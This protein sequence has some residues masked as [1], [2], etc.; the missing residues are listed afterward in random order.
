MR[1]LI[2]TL[3]A[4]LA[5]VAIPAG[6]TSSKLV[7][8]HSHWDGTNNDYELKFCFKARAAAPGAGPMF[9]YLP[10]RAQDSQNYLQLD[11]T[12]TGYKLEKRISGNQTVIAPDVAPAAAPRF[13]V[14]SDLMV[15]LVAQGPDITVYSL[16]ANQSRG[17]RLYHWRDSTYLTGK[18]ISY[19]TQ[20]KWESYWE[21]V[22]LI[23]LDS[24]SERHDIR[25]L[26]QDARNATS[27]GGAATFDDAHPSAGGST[28]RGHSETYGIAQAGRYNLTFTVTGSGTGHVDF[29]DPV[30]DGKFFTSGFYR[31]NIGSSSS[32]QLFVGTSPSKTWT[33][34]KGGPGAY[35]VALN[36]SAV[37]VSRNGAV[38]G[39]GSGG[40][41]SG[42]RLRMNP[43]PTQTWVWKGAP[44]SGT[45]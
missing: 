24:A 7:P 29:L 37:T 12:T 5:L 33:L 18:Y 15:D 2:G 32:L 19:Y 30:T 6:A 31:L 41:S 14:G 16:N 25:D 43:A 38:I 13:G 26:T 20:P 35:K 34:G 9:G 8:A 4:V 21:F 3:V 10:F 22:H 23:P 17:T 28:N 40:P 27:P 11:L 42:V 1:Q 39:T 36:G 45:P 44:A